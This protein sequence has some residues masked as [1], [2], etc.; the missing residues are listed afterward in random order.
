MII[1]KGL[2]PAAQHLRHSPKEKQTTIFKRIGLDFKHF[3]DD[4][5][6]FR[7]LADYNSQTGSPGEK[8]CSS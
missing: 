4:K 5:E 7:G 1:Q 3:F 2:L 8:N 6:I